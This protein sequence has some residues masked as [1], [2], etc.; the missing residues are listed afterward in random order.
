MK[1]I[2][3]SRWFPAYTGGG[4]VEVRLDQEALHKRTECS[5]TIFKTAL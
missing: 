2:H 5:L 1:R 3:L 4:G